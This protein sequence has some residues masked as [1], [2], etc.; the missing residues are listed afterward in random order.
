MSELSIA[1][2]ESEHGELLPERETMFL[3]TYIGIQV[4]NYAHATAFFG[5]AVATNN[6]VIL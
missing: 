5:V 2:L 1:E 6:V 3:N 4:N